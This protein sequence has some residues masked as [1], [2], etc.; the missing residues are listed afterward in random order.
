[1]ELDS[2]WAMLD[3]S[4]NRPA[5]ADP[6]KMRKRSKFMKLAQST[7]PLDPTCTGQTVH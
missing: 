1:M 6:A 5:I 3:R 4:Q 7:I 2:L